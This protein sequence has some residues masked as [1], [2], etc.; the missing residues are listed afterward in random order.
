MISIKPAPK[1][2]YFSIRDNLDSDS[3]LT[4]K[5]DRHKEKQLSLKTSTDE[6]LMISI[7]PI[8]RNASFSIRD[9]LD[10]DSNMTEKS[11]PSSEKQLSLKI[12]AETERMISIKPT[13]KNADFSIP[14][15][16]DPDSNLTEKHARPTKAIH[17]QDFNRCRKND[18]DQASSIE[19]LL[20]NSVQ[21]RL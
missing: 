15:N 13:P 5:N 21:S 16:L 12:S 2:A 7:K 9:N 3:N 8:S 6:R 1:N 11:D 14:C 17:T 19:C 10:P 4:E 18:F 20:F